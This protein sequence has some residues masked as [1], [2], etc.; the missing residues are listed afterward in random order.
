VFCFAW[1]CL[2][3]DIADASA[4]QGLRLPGVIR[5]S[6]DK[7]GQ[8]RIISYSLSNY[9]LK[10]VNAPP[11]RQGFDCALHLQLNQSINDSLRMQVLSPVWLLCLNDVLRMVF[12]EELL[13]LSQNRPMK[14]A[15]SNLHQDRRRNSSIS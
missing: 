2:S 4:L 13:M 6:S 8:S 10:F 14:M 3:F 1:S 9:L 5:V 15:L 7:S 12:L 11:I